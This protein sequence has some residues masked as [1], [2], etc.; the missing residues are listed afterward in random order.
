MIMP[1]VVAT[2]RLVQPLQL[3]RQTQLLQR[4]LLHG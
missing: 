1:G 2:R 4:L 3:L